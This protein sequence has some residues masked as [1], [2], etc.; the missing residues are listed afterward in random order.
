MNPTKRSR[1]RRTRRHHRLPVDPARSPIA[2]RRSCGARGDGVAPPRPRRSEASTACSRRARRWC[3]TGRASIR[4]GRPAALLDLAARVESR[5]A[6]TDDRHV[7]DSGVHAE[8]RWCQRFSSMPALQRSRLIRTLNKV[9]A[10]SVEAL[11]D[12]IQKDQR[13][14][15]VD[16]RLGWQRVWLTFVTAFGQAD[17]SRQCPELAEFGNPSANLAVYIIGT[18]FHFHLSFK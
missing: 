17:N 13:P 6:R 4:S 5:G 3:R 2:A 14:L 15:I 11:H 10:L 16:V 7:D 9:K 12:I 18:Q 8:L 1:S